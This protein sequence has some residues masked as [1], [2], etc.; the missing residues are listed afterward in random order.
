MKKMM[1]KIATIAGFCSV[2]IIVLMTEIGNAK[3]QSVVGTTQQKLNDLKKV[4]SQ[5]CNDVVPFLDIATQ[6]DRDAVCQ[7]CAEEYQATGNEEGLKGCRLSTLLK[8][9]QKGYVSI[10]LITP[11][12]VRYSAL[13][14]EEKVKKAKDSGAAIK[15]S[16]GYVFKFDNGKSI[17]EEKNALPVIRAKDGYVLLDG[18]HDVLSSKELGAKTVPIEVKEDM[19]NLSIN[20]PTLWEQAEAKKLVY[21]YDLSGKRVTPP[22]SFDTMENDPNRFFATLIMHRCDTDASGKVSNDYSLSKDVYGYTYPVWIKINK[23]TPFIEFYI[24]D[25][26]NKY[27]VKYEDKMGKDFGNFVDGQGNALAQLAEDARKVLAEHAKELQDEKGITIKVIPQKTKFSRA[28]CEQFIVGLSAP[29]SLPV[30]PLPPS[31]PNIAEKKEHTI[32]IKNQWRPGISIGTNI[33]MIVSNPGCKNSTITPEFNRYQLIVNEGPN[34]TFVDQ[35]PFDWSRVCFKAIIPYG[36]VG[37]F[38]ISQTELNNLQQKTFDIYIF[39]ASNRN[40]VVKRNV[41][42]DTTINFL[43]FAFQPRNYDSYYWI[44]FN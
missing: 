15:K 43:D 17:V 34:E 16:G 3:V 30:Q 31:N 1:K 23:D 13:N 44:P 11:G 19:S 38:K 14:V 8:K 21:L 39:A 7:L 32:T 36:Q 41:P 29:A 27:K 33:V 6:E 28:L 22:P 25:L 24:S 37:I 4:Q 5:F 18:H 20:D 12:Q 26:L 10:K 9:G 42:V 35:G 40:M 2:A